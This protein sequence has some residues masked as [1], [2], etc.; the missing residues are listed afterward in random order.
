MGC[1]AMT[2]LHHSY[3][4]W[5]TT[6]PWDMP[7][8]RAR[9]TPDT[10]TEGRRIEAGDVWISFEGAYRADTGELVSVEING[11]TIAPHALDAM[12]SALCAPDVVEGWDDDLPEDRL[13]ELCA[14]AASDAEADWADHQ[15][16]MR[17]DERE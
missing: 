12:L 14:A 10:V 8:R 17:K 3:D 16:D 6:P 4:A 13:L 2:A 1:R 5:R 15:N 9:F 11:K 7:T